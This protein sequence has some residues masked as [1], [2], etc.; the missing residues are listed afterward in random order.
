MFT[1]LWKGCVCSDTRQNLALAW[2]EMPSEPQSVS[3]SVDPVKRCCWS[4]YAHFCFYL[5]CSYEE[6]TPSNYI[7]RKQRLRSILQQHQQYLH[8]CYISSLCNILLLC[9]TP[10]SL[11]HYRLP[12]LLLP[13]T[14]WFKPIKLCCYKY[15][16]SYS[17]L[18][19]TRTLAS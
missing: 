7:G 9:A 18:G 8:V 2:W 17:I 14:S 13:C 15:G 4:C 16:G 12:N 19:V 1:S 3:Q 5:G 10:R 6:I 11:L